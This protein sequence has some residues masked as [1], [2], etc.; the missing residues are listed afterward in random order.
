MHEVISNKKNGMLLSS[1]NAKNLKKAINWIKKNRTKK[2]MRKKIHT[3]IVKEVSY[4]TISKK[5][6]FFY[7]SIL[8]G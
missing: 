8:H 3:N 1:F 7:S 2:F 6:I 4:E 5:I